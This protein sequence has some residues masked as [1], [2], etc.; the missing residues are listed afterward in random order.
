MSEKQR[1]KLAKARKQIGKLTSR[2]DGLKRQLE[3][4]RTDRDTMIERLHQERE[5]HT[6]VKGAIAQ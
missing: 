5:A 3:Y 2:V 6:K 1:K 4:L